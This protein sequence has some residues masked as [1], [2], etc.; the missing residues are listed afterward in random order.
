MY[1]SKP[2][3]QGTQFDGSP[4]TPGQ[5]EGV[6]QFYEALDETVP[7]LSTKGILIE[8]ESKGFA[9]RAFGGLS[10]RIFVLRINLSGMY[11]FTSGAL[12]GSINTTI[13]Y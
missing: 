3:R 9:Y 11:N 2:K 12:G 8:V 1:T 5:I 13:Q 10:L 7:N 4:I 6:E